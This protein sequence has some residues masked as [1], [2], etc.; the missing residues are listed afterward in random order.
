MNAPISYKDL[1]K[2]YESD[3]NDGSPVRYNYQSYGFGTRAKGNVYLNQDQ[4]SLCNI[5]TSKFSALDFSGAET[6]G[7]GG[8]KV[9]ADHIKIPP[10]PYVTI[11]DFNQLTRGGLERAKGKSFDTAEKCLK[12]T[13]GSPKKGNKAI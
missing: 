1:S 3:S 10:K 12:Q 4:Y 13:A 11:I 8:K 7:R 5:K 6:R 2:C 9:D